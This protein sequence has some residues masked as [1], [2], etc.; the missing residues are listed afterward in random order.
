M[1]RFRWEEEKEQRQ[2]EYLKRHEYMARL[3]VEDRL[4]FERERK[5]LLDEFFNGIEDEDRRRLCALCRRPSK[6]K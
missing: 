2:A 5:R 1:D 3:F 4:T 6:R